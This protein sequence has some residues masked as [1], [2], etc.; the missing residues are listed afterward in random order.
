MICAVC[1]GS[2]SILTTLRGLQ[3]W[4]C[5]GCGG[6]GVHAMNGPPTFDQAREARCG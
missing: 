1:K 6:A 5:P 3:W 4:Q 2:G